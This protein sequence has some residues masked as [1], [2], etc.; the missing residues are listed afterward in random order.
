MSDSYHYNWLDPIIDTEADVLAIR[1][2]AMELLREG[3]TI[4]SWEGEGTQASKQFVA[5]IQEI[6]AET[7]YCLKQKNPSK[8][9]AIVRQTQVLRLG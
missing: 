6:L 3:K 1:K 4:M 5:P 7:R 2:K 9:G 8:Y